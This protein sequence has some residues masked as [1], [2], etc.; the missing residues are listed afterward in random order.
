MVVYIIVFLM[1]CL[2]AINGIIGIGGLY[3]A[4]KSYKSHNKMALM[5]KTLSAVDN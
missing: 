5:R 3:F 2:V 4:L 1:L